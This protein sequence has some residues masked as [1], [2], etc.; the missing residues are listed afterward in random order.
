MEQKYYTNERNVQIVIALLKAHNIRKVVASPGTTNI[1]FVGSIQQDSW[2]EIYSSVDERSAAYLAC[3]L[4]AESGE[5]VVLSCTG[6]TASRN[7][8]SGL[9][10]AFYRKLP[11]VA[12]TSHQGNHCIG[13]LIAQ[14]IDR[15]QQPKDLVKMSVEA[16]LVKN[17]I[18]EKFCTIEVNKALLELRRHGGGPVHINLF[19]TYSG[20]FSVKEIAPVRVIRRY[21]AFDALPEIPVRKVAVFVGAHRHF[22]QEEAKAIDS[23]CATYNAV[24]FCD[25][26]SGYKGEYSVHFSL[27]LVQTHYHSPFKDFDLLIHIG[28]VSGDYYSMEVKAGRVWRVNEDGELRDTFGALTDVFEI[29]EKFFFE[30]YAKEG[31]SEH[32]AI[33]A[34]RAENAQLHSEIPELPFSN[35]WVAQQMSTRLPEGSELHLGILNTLRSW[36]F[37]DI[38]ETVESFCNVGGFGI[39]GCVSA[40]VGASLAD[41]QKLYFGVFGDLALFYDMNVL[42]NRH[43][44]NNV[45]ILLV[46]NGRGTEF[47]NYNHPANRFGDD[48]DAYMAAAG[49]FGNKSRQL[50]RHL[51]ED[52]GYEYLSCTNKEEFQDALDRFLTPKLT[53]KPMLMEAF[54]DSEDES[55]ALEI[56]MSF[57]ISNK[58][59]AKQ[60]VKRVVKQVLGEKAVEAAKHIMH[61]S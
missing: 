4:A 47:R 34:C 57:K 19:T 46:N 35:L 24:V 30:H 20:D 15:R 51:A 16:P 61:K 48:A 2:F 39:D 7:Y 21:T 36:N 18:D 40:L 22:T 56:I 54:T 55:K 60:K 43:V 44:G 33:D 58:D 11:I 37:F 25:H 50:M 41:R 12:L 26:T 32:T 9:T 52:W 27:P 42:G 49:H 17:G 45:R 23:F 10:E 28:E 13:H 1:T 38:S 31:D 53:D 3:G 6:A 59:L 8:Y 5:P 14:N 29:P